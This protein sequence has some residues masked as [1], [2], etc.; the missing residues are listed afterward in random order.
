MLGRS[1]FSEE[2][3]LARLDA[4][5][6]ECEDLPFTAHRDARI[7]KG[8]LEL[9]NPVFDL[10]STFQLD[11]KFGEEYRDGP[12][13]TVRELERFAEDAAAS[14]NCSLLQVAAVDYSMD[15]EWHPG[16]RPRVENTRKALGELEWIN[17]ISTDCAARV[18]GALETIDGFEAC[19][20]SRHGRFW[21][22]VLT[23]SPF[24]YKRD[25]GVKAKCAVEARLGLNT[26]HS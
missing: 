10:P 25:V 1:E 12:F 18:S 2:R 14:F 5:H 15:S 7:A 3:V 17:V 8:R 13:E 4:W 22:L 24:S 9:T 19:R 23:D 6:N 16:N 21:L 20:A 26:S 11:F